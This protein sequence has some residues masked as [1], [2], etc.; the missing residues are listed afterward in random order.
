[1]GF[2]N[3]VTGQMYLQNARLSLNANASAMPTA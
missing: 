3:T 1:M 2:R